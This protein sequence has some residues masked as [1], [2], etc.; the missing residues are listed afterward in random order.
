MSSG[1]LILISN[2]FS[3]PPKTAL[4]YIRIG[5]YLPPYRDMKR[6]FSIV[7]LIGK[8]TIVGIL[9][10]V[11]LLS[12]IGIAESDST[13]PA[14]DTTCELVSISCPTLEVGPPSP[15][16]T[17]EDMEPSGSTSRVP[18]AGLLSQQVVRID[19]GKARSPENHQTRVMESSPCPYCFED[20]K[21]TISTSRISSRLARQFTLVGAKPSGTG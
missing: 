7:F 1:Y 4:T 6:L 18:K 21:P 8:R 16:E 19:T 12:G 20:C 14:E 3:Q 9:V 17:S 5:I 15:E 2:R 13:N 10:P 11:L